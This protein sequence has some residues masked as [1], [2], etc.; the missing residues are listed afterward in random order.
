MRQY[1]VFDNPRE[2]SRDFAPY[3]VVLQSH[4]V[5]LDSVVVAPLVNDKIASGI[6]IGVEFN[7]EPLIAALTELATVARA[8]L[9][10][11]RGDLET[12]EYEIQ[13]GLNRLFTGF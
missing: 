3:L 2:S 1:A 7:G 4:Y 13:R 10:R 5:E 11:Q 6:D 12:Y 9:R 8:S